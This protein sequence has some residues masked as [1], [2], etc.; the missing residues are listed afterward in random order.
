[1]EL[2][3]PGIIPRRMANARTAPL[4]FLVELVDVLDADPNPAA[5]MALRSVTEINAGAVPLHHREASGSPLGVLEP[6][7]RGVVLDAR[8]HVGD[9]ENRLGMLEASG[10]GGPPRSQGRS[11]EVTRSASM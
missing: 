5:R 3:R 9:G 8:A 2:L 4:V 10:H 7:Y 11:E 6:E 1:M